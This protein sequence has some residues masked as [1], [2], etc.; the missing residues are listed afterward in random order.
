[1][2][3]IDVGQIKTHSYISDVAREIHA[4]SVSWRGVGGCE[5]AMLLLPYYAPSLPDQ[6][7][8]LS[9]NRF[10]G[11]FLDICALGRENIFLNGFGISR[12][13]APEKCAETV[14]EVVGRL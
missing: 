9:W 11:W 7:V 8:F 14:V 6:N 5:D 1:M 2:S 3:K 13:A 12:Y 4:D 10:S